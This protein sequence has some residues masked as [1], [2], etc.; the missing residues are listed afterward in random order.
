MFM[1]MLGIGQV[2]VR[3]GSGRVSAWLPWPWVF[4]RTSLRFF[5]FIVFEN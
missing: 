5:Y 2:M 1:Y 3:Y 4:M